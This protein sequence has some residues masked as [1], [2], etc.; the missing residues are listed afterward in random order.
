MILFNER[1]YMNRK[2]ILLIVF[3]VFFLIILLSLSKFR[4]HYEDYP[5]QIYFFNAGKADAIVL[6]KN[7]KYMMIDTGEE[8]LKNEVLAYFKKNHISKLDYLIITHFDK[9]HVGGAASIISSLEIGE[10][11]QSNVPKNSEYYQEYLSALHDK[12]IVPI[13]VAGDYSISLDDLDIVIN[14]PNIIYDKNESNNS[15]LIVTITDQNN[16]FLFMGDSQNA[17]ISDF[18][19]DHR[20]KYQF[21]KVPYHGHYL[22]RLEEVLNGNSIQYAVITSSSKELEDKETMDLLKKYHVSYYLTRK[23]DLTVYSNG[24]DIKILQ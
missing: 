4:N 8:S 2:I 10:V 13:T 22:K 17:R 3:L 1:G 14:G 15:S 12:N 7:G 20:E 23:G 18:L 16:R 21:L 24:E 9:D 6:S 5:F 11:F 19:V